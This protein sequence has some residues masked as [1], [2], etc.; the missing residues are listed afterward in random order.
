MKIKQPSVSR[1]KQQTDTY[2]PTLRSCVEAVGGDFELVV[3]L[4][5]RRPIRLDRLG[6]V[7]DGAATDES[8]GP[9]VLT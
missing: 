3:R 5:S 6:D 4:P 7:L 9:A 1:I 2:L 8:A